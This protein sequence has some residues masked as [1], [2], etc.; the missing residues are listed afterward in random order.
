MRLFL[1]EGV[2]VIGGIK[3]KRMMNEE[4][5]VERGK[6]DKSLPL[7]TTSF[8]CPFR[9]SSARP[10]ILPKG[11]EDVGARAQVGRLPPWRVVSN[12]QH[13]LVFY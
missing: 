2:T 6:R 12:A 1:V 8:P 11:I 3:D 9:L 5:R 7:C 10:K 4:P 13:R